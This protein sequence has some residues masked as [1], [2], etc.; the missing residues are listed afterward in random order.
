MAPLEAGLSIIRGTRPTRSKG[1][2]KRDR[3]GPLPLPYSGRRLLCCQGRVENLQG[4]V[5]GPGAETGSGTVDTRLTAATRGI[6]AWPPQVITLT[7]SWRPRA[8]RDSRLT[9]GTQAGPIAAG[10]KSTI[11][12]PSLLSLPEFCGCAWAEVASKAM[13]VASAFTLSQQITNRHANKCRDS[14]AE[15]ATHN[16][17]GD[18]IAPAFGDGK[19]RRHRRAD[20]SRR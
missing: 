8:R 17:R 20:Q 2:T 14:V 19:A 9:G 4:R 13:A 10:V 6:A 18:Q 3:Q 7:L 1:V 15:Y 5:P 16:P 11:I 12:T